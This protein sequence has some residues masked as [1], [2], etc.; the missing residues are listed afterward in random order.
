M[1]PCVRR[2]TM[3]DADL[4]GLYSVIED[5]LTGRLTGEKRQWLAG[6]GEGK[7]RAATSAWLTLQYSVAD[8]MARRRSLWTC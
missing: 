4:A 2:L 3:C 8:I 1:R 5:R 7:V 6:K